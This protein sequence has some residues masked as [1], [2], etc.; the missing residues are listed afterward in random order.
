M[1]MFARVGL[2]GLFGAIALLAWKAQAVEVPLTATEAAGVART[3]E[4]VTTGVP[5]AKGV[6]KDVQ[7]LMLKDRAD[8]AGR[9]AVKLLSSFEPQEMVRLRGKG[10][11]AQP[12][13][14][15][16]DR[17]PPAAP[18]SGVVV[19]AP[20]PSISR[21]TISPRPTPPTGSAA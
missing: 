4:P 1:R 14:N 20:A 9:P 6:L 16:F 13:D 2:A 5:F 17:K 3:A 7:T 12:S 10:H 11:Q 15:L 8:T 19:K 18:I 21:R